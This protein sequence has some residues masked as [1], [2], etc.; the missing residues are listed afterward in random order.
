MRRAATTLSA[1]LGSAAILPAAC[2]MTVEELP[3]LRIERYTLQRVADY[4]TTTVAGCLELHVAVPNQA[5][6]LVLVLP[7]SQMVEMQINDKGTVVVYERL[8]T[9][10]T[11]LR[12]EV[13]APETVLKPEQ[14]KALVNRSRTP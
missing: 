7:S 4:R 5:N 14:V 1:L 2:V 13:S 11:V 8:A 9:A 12:R 10:T 6:G 3:G